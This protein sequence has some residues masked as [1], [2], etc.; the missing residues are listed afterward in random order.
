MLTQ[1]QTIDIMTALRTAKRLAN[2]V[3]SE[4][5]KEC[6]ARALGLLYV[7]ATSTVDVDE[8]EESEPDQKVYTMR[9]YWKG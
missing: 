9:K 4:F 2:D 5:D 6:I 7:A 1:S 8:E 3:G